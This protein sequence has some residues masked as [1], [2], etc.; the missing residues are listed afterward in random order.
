MIKMP[1]PQADY[2][3][4]IRMVPYDLV[5]ELAIALGASLVLILVLAAVLSS[6]DVP[7]V[8]IQSWAQAD[9]VDFVTTAV[10]ELA[11]QT[12]T[13]LYGPPYT[14][15]S[16]SVQSLGPISPQTWAGVRQPIDQPPDFVISPLQHAS[17]GDA[18][19]TSALASFQAASSAQQGTWLTNYTTALGNATVQGGKVVTAPGDYGPAPVLM[20]RLLGIARTGGLDG[21]LLASGHFYQTDFTKPLLFMNDGG[22]LAGLATDQHLTGTQ[23]GMMNETGR[24]PGQTWLW[25]YTMW[26]QV[27]P[28]NTSANADLLVVG[29]VGL[30]TLLLVL[31]P[32]IPG[33]RDI[34]RWIPIHRVVWRQYYAKRDTT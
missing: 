7:A 18:Q 11:G 23:W 12:T 33:I 8:T 3:R 14:S 30:L 4:G 25:L 2:Y 6:P 28:F 31:V 9:P 26:Y 5:K 19:V 10:N 13:A 16:G 17:I 22:Y 24:Y 29:M 20:D 1:S 21:L 27:P 32:F 15:G 34:P